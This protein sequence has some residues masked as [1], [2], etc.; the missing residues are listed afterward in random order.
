MPTLAEQIAPPEKRKTVIADLARFVDDEM[1]RKGGLSGLAIKGSYAVVKAI[2]PTFIPEVIDGMLDDWLRKLEPI[3]AECVAEGPGSL[4]PRFAKRASPVADALL[5]VT[6]QRS[7]RT[8]YTTARK[9]YQKL[10]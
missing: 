8:K 9:A 6:D 7:E 3:Y 10:R 1:G 4:G 2:K 5:S